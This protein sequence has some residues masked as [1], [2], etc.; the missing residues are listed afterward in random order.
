MKVLCK[1][2][3]S[4]LSG[5]AGNLKT[6]RKRSACIERLCI[7]RT[8]SQTSEATLTPMNLQNE[9]NLYL[10]DNDEEAM[11]VWLAYHKREKR[12]LVVGCLVFSDRLISENAFF[13]KYGENNDTVRLIKLV[14]S[15]DVG[16][17]GIGVQTAS[18]C[19][20]VE[21]TFVNLNLIFNVILNYKFKTINVI[22]IY[23]IN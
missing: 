19:E 14:C 23:L 21:N 6:F 7:S 11:T 4:R 8:N 16:R 13:A 15:R 2:F 22:L 12:N 5:D 20:C 9:L 3:S 10:K 17:R 1:L 18:K